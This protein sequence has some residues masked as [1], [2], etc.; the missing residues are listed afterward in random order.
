MVTV[1]HTNSS[2]SVCDTL[3]LVVTQKGEAMATVT[4]LVTKECHLC[5]SAREALDRVATKTGINWEEIDVIDRPDLAR[6]YGDRLPVV[7]LNDKE[8]SYW[9][10][11]E[12]R[13]EQ[14]LANGAS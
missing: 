12:A 11:D 14:D 13:L 10:V 2:H 8:H 3:F 1:F 6:E 4:L 9:D 5:G 7:L